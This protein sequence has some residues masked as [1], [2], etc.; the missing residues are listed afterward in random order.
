MDWE[1]PFPSEEYRERLARVR[2]AMEKAGYDGMMI[3]APRDY[4][5]LTGHDHI[6][7]YRAGVTGLYVDVATGALFLFDNPSHRNLISVT[8]EITDVVYHRRKGTANE[9]VDDVVQQIQAR[10][11]GRGRTA[12]QTQGYGLHPDL[13]RRLGRGLAA[14]GGAEI[15]E[16][17]RLIED[18]RLYKSPREIAVMRD[19]AAIAVDT[20]RCL[21][22][23]LR[24]GM[25]ETEID[26]IIAYETMRRGCGHPAI[27]TMIG[28]GPRSGAHHGPATSRTLTP[29]DVLHVDFCASLHRYHANVSRSFAIGAIDPRWH[30]LM[31]RSAGTTSAILTAAR[32]GD[33]FSRVQD[34]ADRF[35]AAAGIDRDRYEWFIGG[36]VLGIAFPPDWVHRHRPAPQPGEDDPVLRPGMIFNFEVQ[37]DVFEGWP[38]GSGAGWID[39]FLMTE[40]GLECLTDLP[41]ELAVIE[42]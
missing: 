14:S 6:W 5:Y 18:V 38:G 16:D 35:V 32:P 33:P 1:Q 21:R 3:T 39:T 13:V 37:Y 29:G 10:G 36:Y 28:S 9:Q 15:V 27:R 24:T 11:L 4:Y 22:D 31:D 26:A 23:R 42:G 17:D 30:D 41:R 34:A 25:A 19:A 2:G 12:I 40:D 8:P 7:Q 20:M